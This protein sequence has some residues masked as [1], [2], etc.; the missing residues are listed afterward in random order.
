M[1][2]EKMIRTEIVLCALLLLLV[3]L[4]ALSLRLAR[5][6]DM[7]RIQ[8]LIGKVD[9]NAPEF[10][11]K[12]LKLLYEEGVTEEELARGEKALLAHSYTKDG[13]TFLSRGWFSSATWLFSGAAAV[14][15]AAAAVFLIVRLRNERLAEQEAL[16][17]QCE[18]L[19]NELSELQYVETRNRDIKA[20][21]EN[22]AHQLKTPVSRIMGSLEL[23]H[24]DEQEKQECI[25]HASEISTLITSLIEIGRMEAGAVVFHREDL[26]LQTLIRDMAERSAATGKVTVTFVLSDDSSEGLSTD[27]GPEASKELPS[28]VSFPWR[29]DYDWMEE[30]LM[31]LVKN[32]L[33]HDP[34][35]QAEIECVQEKDYYRIRIRDHG[36]GFSEED[37]PYLFDRF[38]Q[39]L[40]EKKGHTGI[41]MNLAKLILEGHHAS[42]RAANSE[43]GGA[44]FL[45][46]LPRFETLNE[47]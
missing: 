23:M 20:F 43:T 10:T 7:E 35:G 37:L 40:T 27:A 16:R 45:I 34:R 33:E 36:P 22:I 26:D 9:A 41:G 4:P 2:N 24:A 46:L 39:P 31:N 15:L 25:S 42:I 11:E 13:L 47:K 32:C 30:A 8:A 12:F 1:K 44:E 19:R 5:G 17:K 14:L 21:I 18:E 28:G 3:L 6:Q 29:G 38:Y